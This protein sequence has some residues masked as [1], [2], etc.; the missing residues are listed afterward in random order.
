M[1]TIT[2]SSSSTEDMWKETGEKVNLLQVSGIGNEES[3]E[4]EEVGWN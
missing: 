3:M 2:L 1:Y 4:N